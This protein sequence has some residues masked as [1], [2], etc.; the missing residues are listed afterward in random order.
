M[1]GSRKGIAAVEEIVEI[2]EVGLRRPD[3][4]VRVEARRRAAAQCHVRGTDAHAPP[5]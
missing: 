5:H 1:P 4:D 3:V 2:G